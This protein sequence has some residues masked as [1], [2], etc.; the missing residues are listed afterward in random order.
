MKNFVK[1][2]LRWT[3]RPIIKDLKYF[4]QLS[5]YLLTRKSISEK[6]SV[7]QY[8]EGLSP[9]YERPVCLFCSYDKDSSVKESVYY[10]LNALKLAGFDIIFISTSEMIGDADLEKL[11]GYCIRIMCRENKGYDF[12]GWKTAL[13]KYPQYKLHSGL[14]LA[15]DSVLGPLFDFSDIVARLE[16]SDADIIGMTN[17]FQ[18]HPHLQSYFLYCKKKVILS[19]EFAHFFQKVEVLELKIAI[20]RRYEVGFSRLLGRHFRIM[21]LYDL[22]QLV[23]RV[24][25]YEKPVKW[26]NPFLLWKPLITEFKFPFLKKSLLTG[27]KVKDIGEIPEVIARYTTYDLYTLAGYPSSYCQK[28]GSSLVPEITT[29]G[30]KDASFTKRA[31]P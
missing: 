21:A 6:P 14:L 20:I 5:F 2:H 30:L 7:R 22:R 3:L 19:E 17:S 8:K 11:S 23:A 10:Y 18:F 31:T 13:E 4:R 12:Y 1:W 24:G 9:S 26:V 25:Y 28:L 27:K 16:N 29:Q 15:N